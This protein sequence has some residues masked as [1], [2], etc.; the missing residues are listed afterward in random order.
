VVAS[1]T[2][3]TEFVVTNLRVAAQRVLADRTDFT[4]TPE[5]RRAWEAATRRPARTLTGL[6]ELMNRPSP[7]TE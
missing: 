2:A 1:D 6:R 7:F 5:A 4:L 3:L